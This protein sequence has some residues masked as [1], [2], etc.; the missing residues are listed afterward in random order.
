MKFRYGPDTTN[1]KG[2]ARARV[3]PAMSWHSDVIGGLEAAG[4]DLVAFLPDSVLGPLIDRI[5][6]TDITTVRVAR[7]E[8]GVG[9]LSG[10]WLGGRRGALVCQTSGLANCFNAL[11]SLA[12]PAGLPFV[13]L[14]SRRGDLGDH[15]RA[16][17][18]AGYAMPGLLDELGIRHRTLEAGDDP[19]TV[20][21]LAA[22]TAFSVHDPYVILLEWTLTGGKG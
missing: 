7:E 22:E 14:V 5:D 8:A 12:V 6:E 3:G 17:V 11:G 4:I 16:Q 1:E 2:Y 9:L 21:D 18:P 19:E 20:V 15:N 10:A 13:G